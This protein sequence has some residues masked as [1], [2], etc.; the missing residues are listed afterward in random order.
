MP[1]PILLDS[2]SRGF[3]LLEAMVVVAIAGILIGFSYTGFSGVLRRQRC[4]AAAQK[5]AW[6]LKQ[7]QMQA[8]E[9]HIRLNVKVLTVDD[10]MTIDD[11]GTVIEKVRIAKDFKGVDVVSGADFYF[12][13]RGIP[14]G[15]LPKIK[16]RCQNTA[17]PDGNV[18][19]S[20]MGRITIATPDK[21]Q[22]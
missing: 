1:R 8:V 13:T 10:N 19:V 6:V 21:W 2:D 14:K 20:S 11:N 7:A 15:T 5:V 18:T 16:L 4:E 3:T 22:Y 9:K 12:S 17:G